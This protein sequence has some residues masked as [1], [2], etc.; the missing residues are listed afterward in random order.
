MVG[1]RPAG[2]QFNP[3]RIGGKVGLRM[4]ALAASMEGRLLV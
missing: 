4:G 1:V 3:E 2:Y